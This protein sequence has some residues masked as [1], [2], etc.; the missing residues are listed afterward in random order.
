MTPVAVDD[1]LTAI[2]HF[3]WHPRC[4]TSGVT[5]KRAAA[6]LLLVTTAAAPGTS[7]VCIGWCF[8]AE[9]PTTT[10]CHH[11][12][13]ILGIKAADENCDRVLAISPFIKEE[14]QLIVQAVLP[15]S[16]PP[17]FSVLV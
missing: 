17:G 5:I 12:S 2:L 14:T 11:A 7:V 6:V 16:T 9:A 10:A 1:F 3:D 15:A 4:A 8:P 13:E